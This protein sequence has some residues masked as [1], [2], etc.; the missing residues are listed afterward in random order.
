MKVSSI[1]VNHWF[2]LYGIPGTILCN[3]EQKFVSYVRPC[4]CTYL[5]L[6]NLT[7]TVYHPQTNR[8]VE[9]YHTMP[10]PII[11][12][13]VADKQRHWNE[14]VQPQNYAYNSQPRRLT[15]IISFLLTISQHPSCTTTIHSRS[16]LPIYGYKLT[17]VQVLHTRFPEKLETRKEKYLV[18]SQ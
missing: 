18:T 5:G 8:N 9:Q 4:K 12:Y 2:I 11:R 1:F 7:N 13:Y 14:Y 10:V 15:N 3:Y 17:S 16:A 6:Q